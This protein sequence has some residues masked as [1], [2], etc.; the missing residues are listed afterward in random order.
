MSMMSEPC[1]SGQ[2]GRFVRR[3][4]AVENL[5]MEYKTKCDSLESR[6]ES[7]EKWKRNTQKWL[8]ENFGWSGNPDI[9]H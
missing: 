7:V 2:P 5:L 1:T 3:L 8:L 6:C 9:P 4:E